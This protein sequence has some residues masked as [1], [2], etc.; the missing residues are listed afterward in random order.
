MINV[1][2]PKYPGKEPIKQNYVEVN[3]DEIPD[4][5]E[6]LSEDND[7]IPEE[8]PFDDTPFITPEPGEGP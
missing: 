2:D 4:L 8:D 3:P 7:L 1:T 6:T 5:P